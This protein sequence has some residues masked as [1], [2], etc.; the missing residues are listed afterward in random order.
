VPDS[1]SAP[2]SDECTLA[3]QTGY[4]YLHVQRRQ[5]ED[6]PMPRS[7]G[8]LLQARCGCPCHGHAGVFRDSGRNPRLN[9]S[10]NRLNDG[11]PRIYS[12]GN[13]ERR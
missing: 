6:V 3:Q 5:T 4:A 13:A 8:L 10:E 1:G 11:D 12:L 7:R 2:P 9:V